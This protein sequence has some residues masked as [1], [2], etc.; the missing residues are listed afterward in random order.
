MT[1][2]LL[3]AYLA[4]ALLTYGVL[5]LEAE[6]SLPK[7]VPNKAAIAVQAVAWPLWLAWR[8]WKSE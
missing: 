2:F 6:G 8:A 7:Q 1:L 5:Y 3:L 4:V